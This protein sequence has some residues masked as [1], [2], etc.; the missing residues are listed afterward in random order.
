HRST[1]I[2]FSL[3]S[4]GA[5]GPIL[6]DDT[7]MV[8]IPE[9]AVNHVALM[10]KEEH[11]KLLGFRMPADLPVSNW[12]REAFA[13]V[14][15]P[16]SKDWRTDGLVSHVK[17]QR[18]CGSCWAFSAVGALEGQQAKKKG[19]ILEFSEQ[20]LVDCSS[21]FGNYGCTGGLMDNA[22]Q[23]VKENGGIDTEDSY[24]YMGDEETCRFNNNTIGER[25]SGF[26]DLPR[27][28]ENALKTAVATIGPI[29]VAIDA[30]HL[31]FMRYKGGV[32][33]EEEC[34]GIKLNHAV[35]VVGYGTDENEGDY[36]LVK[37][38]YGEGW[39]EDGYIRIVRNRN[40]HCGIAT[41]ASY[42]IV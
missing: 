34:N 29:S 7:V 30:N 42:P 25:D 5:A 41:Y 10:T 19:E 36:W 14:D 17:D 18:R 32:F 26:V 12:N 2:L 37:N 39:G 21:S 20:N 1:I 15:V 4:I 6:P 16:D 24:P 8:E 11:K 31:S 28:D 38:S 3:V 13:N 40:N 27:F 33:Y 35:L 23:Y 22:F 9:K